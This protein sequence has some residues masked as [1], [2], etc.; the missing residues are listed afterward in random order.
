MARRGGVGQDCMEG[1]I[2]DPDIGVSGMVWNVHAL[3]S[4]KKPD[5][6]IKAIVVIRSSISLQELPDFILKASGNFD[7]A[8][9]CPVAKAT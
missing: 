2:P 8:G 1:M 9:L 3:M 7:F 4:T 6:S 5:V